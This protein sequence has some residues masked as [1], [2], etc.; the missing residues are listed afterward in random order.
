MRIA[1]TRAVSPALADCELTHLARSPID[2]RLAEKQHAAYESALRE[3]GCRVERLPVAPAYPDSVFVEDCALVL[4]EIA[5]IT[6]PGAVS[7]RGEVAEIDAA[8]ASHRSLLRIEA[9]FTLDGGDVLRLDRTLFVGLSS[10]SSA[11]AVARLD[12]LIRPHGYRAKGLPIRNCLHLKSAVSLVGEKL[13]LL[14]PDWVDPA[15]F[16]DHDSIEVDPGEAHAANALL[17][18]G[19][20]ILPAVHTGTR[21]RLEAAGLESLPLDVS[22]LAKAEGGVTCCSLIV[23]ER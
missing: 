2:L 1:I 3:L 11:E 10:R 7:R 8:L 23:E 21:T 22:E 19:R 4:D 14:N 18:D 12:T 15:L 16:P 13:L 17:L 5:V 9:P 20:I 6:R